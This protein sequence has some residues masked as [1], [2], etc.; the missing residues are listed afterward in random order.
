VIQ[1]CWKTAL[2]AAGEA[3]EPRIV[4]RIATPSAEATCRLVLTIAE[5]V[6][7]RSAGSAVALVLMSVG[8]AR[9][10]PIPV[11]SMLGSRSTT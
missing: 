8:S 6:P 2:A 5:P 3:G 10:T 4:T 11:S 1:P 9:P 7:K